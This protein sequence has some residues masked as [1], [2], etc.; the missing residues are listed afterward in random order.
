MVAAAFDVQLHELITGPLPTSVATTDQ[1]KVLRSMETGDPVAVMRA[2]ADWAAAQPEQRLTPQQRRAV[3]A[4][5][6]GQPAELMSIAAE[7]MRA[8]GGYD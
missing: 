5:A 1:E 2:V 8:Q 7:M 4:I 6:T 3:T